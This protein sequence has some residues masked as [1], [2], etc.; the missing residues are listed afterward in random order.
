PDAAVKL[1][2]RPISRKMA[3]LEIKPSAAART[4][5]AVV[6]LLAGGILAVFIFLLTGGGRNLF[7]SKTTLTT[8]MPDVTG[9]TDKAEVRLSG[10]PIGVVTGIEISGLL[11]PQR[12]VRVRM[13]VSDKFLKNIPSDSET[14]ISSDTLVGFN[15]VSIAEGKSGLPVAENGT[16]RSEP[17]KTAVDRADQVHAMQRELRQV[18]DILIQISSPDTTIG[19]FIVGDTEYKKLLQQ[20]SAFAGSIHAFV[21]PNSPTGQALFS[22]ALY[23]RI[24]D[25]VLKLDKMLGAMQRG[26][27]AAGRVFTS[28]EQYTQLVKTLHDL[29]TGLSDINAGKGQL[30]PLLHDDAYYRQVQKMLAQTDALITSLNAGEGAAGRLLRNPQLYEALNG[31]LKSLQFL[32]TDL[33][34]NPKKYLRYK[35]F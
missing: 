26:E 13:R 8:Y 30:G 12:I 35:V 29:R 33:R 28:D 5:V 2:A 3:E 21:G 18:D 19:Q 32:L 25:P 14:S 16:L 23:G 10:I 6:M 22:N 24:H 9:L 11:D 4:R 1:A 34:Q 17:F 31:S 27:G 20:V 15:F 7:E